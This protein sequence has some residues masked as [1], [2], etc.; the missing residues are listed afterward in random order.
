MSE[1]NMNGATGNDDDI[2][3]SNTGQRVGAIIV[4]LIAIAGAI[5]VVWHFNEKA[6]KE[7]AI[8]KVK[9]DFQ[10]VHTNGYEAFW[11][12]TQID[13]KEIKSNEDFG[14]KLKEILA[15]SSVAYN[16]HIKKKALPI[17]KKA[18]TDFKAIQAPSQF[19]DSIKAV[20]NAMEELQDAWTST[21]K[22]LDIYETYL[23]SREE[24]DK[25][26]GQWLG[27]QQEP[28]NEEYKTKGIA[29]INTIQCI[30]TNTILMDV[31]NPAD[32]ATFLKNTCAKAD[33]K[34]DWF[35]HAAGEC[36]PKL[37]KK[38]AEETEVITATIKHYNDEFKKD[39]TLDNDS[40]F[41]VKECLDKSRN[42]LEGIM[43]DRIAKA[44]YNYSKAKN[45]LI[46][47]IDEEQKK[48][49]K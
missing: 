1:E 16:N 37:L 23:E 7:A 48:L 20:T 26:G 40:V 13:L 8:D 6:K 46:S 10:L 30:M 34:A 21:T 35:R 25:S 42:M 17:L 31:E 29:Y 14:I 44:W 38:T 32:L 18:V 41:A 39:G 24:L 27:L 19:A 45:T 2:K 22:E 4:A 9:A 28:D 5:A 33:A 36:M 47:L 12:M 15:V 3:I 43:S 11:K 49:R